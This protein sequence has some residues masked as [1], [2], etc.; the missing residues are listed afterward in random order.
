MLVR[1]LPV[2]LALETGQMG[3]TEQG[4]CRQR[5]G[6]SVCV[7]VSQSGVYLSIHSQCAGL[8]ATFGQTRRLL[9]LTL[10]IHSDD[11]RRKPGP[12]FS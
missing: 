1:K 10:H 3:R 2:K 6:L 11:L 8:C 9:G 4:G 12:Y 5:A 7:R